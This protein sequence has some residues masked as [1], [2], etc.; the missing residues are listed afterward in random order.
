MAGRIV[1][2]LSNCDRQKIVQVRKKI[3]TR[4]QYA[5]ASDPGYMRRSLVQLNNEAVQL[6]VA[7]DA[8]AAIIVYWKLFDR[9]RAYNLSHIELHV[10]YRQAS[11]CVLYRGRVLGYGDS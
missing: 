8:L 5:Q 2:S 9:A 11:R 3:A 1:M 4:L 10:C 6:H 7:G